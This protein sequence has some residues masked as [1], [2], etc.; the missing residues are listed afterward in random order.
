MRTL[1]VIPARYHSTRLPGKPLVEI[2]GIPLVIRVLR[3]AKRCSLLDRVI[4]ATDDERIAEVVRKDKGEVMMT[5]PDLPSGGDRVAW[6]VKC[7]EDADIV[8]NIQVDDPLVGPKMIGS[9]VEA[10]AQD[11]DCD[12]AV[13][14]KEIEKPEEVEDPN[15][16]KVVF[17]QYFKALYFS[18]SIIPYP[19][20]KGASYYKHI[21]PYAYRRPF[22]LEFA[23][24]GP[25]PLERSE[26]LEMLRVL[27]R[28]RRIKCVP[29]ES[30]TIE[31]D[32][33]EDVERLEAYFRE[34]G[35]DLK[36]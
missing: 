2:A 4:V 32:T 3:Q 15:I 35:D 10:L 25:T 28:G 29:V 21:G 11:E 34:H 26:S 27:E 16:V 5:P 13:A 9:L 22:L 23:S 20:V 12:L 31:I 1:A 24:W 36:W 30:D 19:R 8:L 33:P 18:R 14:V 7:V 6:V 17:D